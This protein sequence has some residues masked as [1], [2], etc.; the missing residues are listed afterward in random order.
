MDVE[1][2]T[3]NRAQEVLGTGELQPTVEERIPVLP[4]AGQ[5]ELYDAYVEAQA[6]VEALPPNQD[7]QTVLTTGSE[8]IMRR[9]SER[10][11]RIQAQ[12]QALE[13]ARVAAAAKARA[14]A[15]AAADARSAAASPASYTPLGGIIGKLENKDATYQ[16]AS[17]N[18]FPQLMGGTPDSTVAAPRVTFNQL[19][20]LGLVRLCRLVYGDILT[21]KLQSR[22]SQDDDIRDFFELTPPQTQ[23]SRVIGSLEGPIQTYCW[24]CGTKLQQP[25]CAEKCVRDCEHRADVAL[26]L[27]TTGL[28]DSVL[29]SILARSERGADEY[30]NLLQHEYAWSHAVC[31]RTKKAAH[32]LTASVNG[33][34]VVQFKA[35]RPAIKTILDSLFSSPKET[36]YPDPQPTQIVTEFTK[37]VWSGDINESEADFRS[38]REGEYLETRPLAVGNALLPLTTKLNSLQLTPKGLC[39]RF[40]NGLLL[41]AIHL[42]PELTKE[43]IWTS[44]PPE[45][46]AIL[47]RRLGAGRRRTHRR[48]RVQKILRGGGLEEQKKEAMESLVEYIVSTISLSTLFSEFG[49]MGSEGTIGNV[50]ELMEGAVD[51]HLQRT[52]GTLKSIDWPLLHFGTQTRVGMDLV[53]H[54]LTVIFAP[55]ALIVNTAAPASAPVSGQS[56]P[57]SVEAASPERTSRGLPSAPTE[58]VMLVSPL[59]NKAPSTLTTTPPTVGRPAQAPAPAPPPAPVGM[60]SLVPAATPPGSL[61][62]TQGDQMDQEPALGRG[63]GGFKFTMGRR[64]DW[65]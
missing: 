59:V 1:S 65:L 26:A 44:L 39:L 10:V 61:Q 47:N 48:N 32:F 56:T 49:T 33:G 8:L 18:L 28:Y 19:F 22:F 29:H 23:C 43:S 46:Q 11:Q 64:P 50:M 58:G 41:R 14:D 52:L 20:T 57:L 16:E 7:A 21:K 40:T 5:D 62:A 9:T 17:T 24:I 15:Q 37:P 55:P 34:G 36:R 42:A 60:L 30:I 45:Y 13:K 4:I 31:N 2:S 6:A 35:D 25:R 38:V 63:R 53:E 27:S 51:T 12:Q 3:I 54:A